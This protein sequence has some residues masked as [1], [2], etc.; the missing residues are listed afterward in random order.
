[1]TNCS[2]HV[3]ASYSDHSSVRTTELYAHVVPELRRSFIEKL[4]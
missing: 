1:M 2:M 3:I 4:D